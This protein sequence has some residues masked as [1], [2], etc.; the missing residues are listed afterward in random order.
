[1]PERVGTPGD[2]R[3][4]PGRLKGTME[5]TP[6]QAVKRLRLEQCWTQE[7]L[8]QI[9]GA[10]RPYITSIEG[11]ASIGVLMAERFASAFDEPRSTFGW[12]VPG[13]KGP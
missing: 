10:T 7:D 13:E 4:G 12:P 2:V 9:T 5:E 11:G 1:M 8:A 3:V 6:Q